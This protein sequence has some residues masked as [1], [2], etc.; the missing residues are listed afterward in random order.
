MIYLAFGD[1]IRQHARRDNI[2]LF[3]ILITVANF[4]DLDFVPGILLD[5]P[6][7]FHHGPSHS[8]LASLIIAALSFSLVQGWFPGIKR[9]NLMLALLLATTSHPVLD[10]FS[11]DYSEPVGVPL[12]WPFAGEYLA[13]PYAL[14]PDI[15][16]DGT[17]SQSFFLSLFSKHNAMALLT[18]LAFGAMLL[19]GTLAR[20]PSA[21]QGRHRIYAVGSLVFLLIFLGSRSI[22]I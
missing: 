7:R 20:S 15:R 9:K 11:A 4:P 10:Y 5:N 1:R 8:L 16:R 13:S 2:A 3:L 17:S 18:E 6:H 12:F 21:R 14:F 22:L 19:L